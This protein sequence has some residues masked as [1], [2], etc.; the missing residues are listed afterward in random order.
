MRDE[1]K[2]ILV[3][4]KIKNRTNKHSIKFQELVD[5]EE[6]VDAM[7]EFAEWYNLINDLKQSKMNI[8]V[9]IKTEE[10]E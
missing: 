2:K 5:R 10:Q 7:M 1:A 6:E 8:N 4:H 9:N 3:K